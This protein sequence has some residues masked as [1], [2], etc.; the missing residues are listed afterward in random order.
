MNEFLDKFY[1]SN[2]KQETNNFK[3]TI[4]SNKIEARI[5][6]LSIKYNPGLK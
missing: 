2:L 6:C 1:I 4:I 5:K 3:L